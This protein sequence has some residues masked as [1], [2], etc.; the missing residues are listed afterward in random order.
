MNYRLGPNVVLRPEY[1]YDWSPALDYE[2]GYFG[3][4]VVA[5]Y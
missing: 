1:R 5:T 3:M 2:Q 4:D